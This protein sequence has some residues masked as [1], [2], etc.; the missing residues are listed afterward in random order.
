WPTADGMVQ[1][2]AS[3]MQGDSS[4]TTEQAVDAYTRGSA[5]SVGRSGEIGCL[6][7][8]CFGDLVVLDGDPM[9]SETGEIPS[10]QVDQVYVAGVRVD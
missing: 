9:K 1:I 3:G 5:V 6:A 7:V 4:L 8:G 10:I 2:W